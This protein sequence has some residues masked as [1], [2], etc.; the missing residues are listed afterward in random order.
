MI[1]EL[2]AACM[3]TCKQSSPAKIVR[4]PS[5]RKRLSEDEFRDLVNEL[6]SAEEHAAALGRRV[7]ELI[8]KA[9]SGGT[10]RDGAATPEKPSGEDS[11]ST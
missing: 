7:K 8:A 11:L 1:C 2:C 3:N 9:L 4:C 6:D 5:F 10:G